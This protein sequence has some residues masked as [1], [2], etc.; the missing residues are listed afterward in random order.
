MKSLVILGSTGSIGMQALE[1]AQ[2]A[3]YRV[4]GLAAARNVTLLEEQIRQFSP[5]VAA[6]YDEAACACG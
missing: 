5:S 6:V 2:Q 3:G 1:V 4:V